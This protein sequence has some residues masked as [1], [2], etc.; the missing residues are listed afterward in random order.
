[1]LQKAADSMNKGV[2][3]KEKSNVRLAWGIDLQ[4]DDIWPIEQK[5]QKNGSWSSGRRVALKRLYNDELDYLTE[6][7]RLV[8]QKSLQLQ[9]SYN[10][11]G[12]NS[13]QYLINSSEAYKLLCEHPH[14]YLQKGTEMIPF[15]LSK[16]E[17]ILQV[18]ST[19]SKLLVKFDEK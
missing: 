14:L 7:D 2:N 5:L 3:T 8:V 15:T 10:D 4:L 9:T 11:W 18:K 16:G 13:N 17:V 19:K 6:Q 1:M 12:Y